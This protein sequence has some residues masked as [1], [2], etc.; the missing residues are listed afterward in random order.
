MGEV[1]GSVC[2]SAG[3]PEHPTTRF[4]FS[5]SPLSPSNSYS[6]LL[7]ELVHARAPDL[8]QQEGD[9]GGGPFLGRLSRQLDRGARLKMGAGAP[10]WARQT[11]VDCSMADAQARCSFAS[12]VSRLE[13][14]DA[15]PA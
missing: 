9:V 12:V 5:P 10:A 7:W 15:G 2:R 8:L 4:S 1:W 3:L 11:F 6:V 14:E 13:A